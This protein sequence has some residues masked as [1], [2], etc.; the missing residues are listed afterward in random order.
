M[1]RAD[2]SNSSPTTTWLGAVNSEI[3]HVAESLVTGAIDVVVL[4]STETEVSVSG[5]DVV[6][7]TST[8][9][10]VLDES[11]SDVVLETSTTE[12]EVLETSL[13]DV[14]DVSA[15]SHIGVVSVVAS[16]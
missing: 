3:S 16:C 13:S 9:E 8:T 14:D 6:L 1:N 11:T 10:V 2:T 4:D 15:T 5:C 12:E 7:E